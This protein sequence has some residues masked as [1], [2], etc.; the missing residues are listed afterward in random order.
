MTCL[1]SFDIE[2]WFHA[3][4]LRPAVS[5][6]EWESCEARV[7]ENTHR[8]LNLLEKHDATAMFFVLGW[9]AERHPHLVEKIG[10]EGHEIASHR[11]NHELLYK[12]S[13]ENIRT[14]L[15]QSVEILGSIVET[16]V[17]GYRGPSF[18]IT[19]EAVEVLDE[20]RFRYDSSS[21]AF[22]A[23][24][25]YGK[26]DTAD[27]HMSGIFAR[28]ANGLLEAR[29]PQVDIPMTGSAIP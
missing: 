11:C 9:I 23:H 29:L 1:L 24:D 14:D 2:D 20:L 8:I 6:A 19:D 3:H 26:L 5:R 27:T 4:N 13:R 15:H 10:E 16:P 18:S 25:R 12:H 21:F 22:K 7:V 17:L 28:L